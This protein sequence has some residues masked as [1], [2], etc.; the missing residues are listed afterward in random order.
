MKKPENALPAVFCAIDTPDLPHALRLSASLAKATGSVKLGLEFFNAQGPQGVRAILA[1]NPGLPLFLD[2]KYHDIPN[3]VAQSVRAVTPLGAAYI[4]VHAA[5]GIA[6]M[7]AA[8]EAAQDE[9]AKRGIT[10]PLILGVTVLTSLTSEDLK[11]AGVGGDMESQVAR[12]ME[13]VLNSGLAGVVCSAH[14]IKALRKRFGSDPVLMVPGIRP[15]GHVKGSD[16]QARV[17]T[18]REAMDAGATHL[19]IGR[20]ITGAPDPEAAARA[21]LAEIDG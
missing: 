12:L 6:M 8:K 9:A 17:M 4:N 3:T 7:K 1:A 20:P 11:Q 16:D 18:P 21:I 19:V 14:E 5:G 10:P 2:L 13:N 15:A